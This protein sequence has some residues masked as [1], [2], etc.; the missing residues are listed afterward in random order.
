[1]D[2][3]AVPS[4]SQY[5][6][7]TAEL[8]RRRVWSG[9]TLAGGVLTAEIVD[10]CQSG[11]S[12]VLAS[13]ERGRALVGRGVACRI[14]ASG[15]IRILLRQTSNGLLLQAV[16]RGGGI[17][18]T[19]TQPSNDRSIQLKSARARIAPLTAE[20]GPAALRQAAAF[21]V[22]L[23]GIGYSEAFAAA[24]CAYEPHELVALDLM[25]EQAFIQTPGPSAG[26]ALTP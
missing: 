12:I 15:E 8:A 3:R 13:A 20:D 6:S 16:E 23:M 4:E 11:I 1:M 9:P 25:P 7:P 5:S 2:R 17:A 22:A 10:F 18:I 21:R 26:S 24:Y 19:Y 14:H